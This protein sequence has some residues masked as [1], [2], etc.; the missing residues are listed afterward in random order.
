MQGC[1]L[2]H[3]HLFTQLVLTESSP[4]THQITEL[5]EIKT[6]QRGSVFNIAIDHLLW[7]LTL[8]TLAVLLGHHGHNVPL[9]SSHP[10]LFLKTLIQHGQILFKENTSPS[11]TIREH[12]LEPEGWVGNNPLFP[13]SLST[14]TPSQLSAHL[15]IKAAIG[16]WYWATCYLS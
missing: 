1:F 16:S 12:P 9:L 5:C 8:I 13:S 10:L 7:S 14:S 4:E 3:H 11:Y 6:K 15:G 2:R